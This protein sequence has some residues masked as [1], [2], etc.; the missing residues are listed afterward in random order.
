MSQNSHHPVSPTQVDAHA[1]GDVIDRHWHDDHQLIYVS[2]GVLA[3]RTEKGAWVAS[4][5]RAIWVPARIWHEHRVYGQTSLHVIGFRANAAP[6]PDTSPTVLTVTGLL[7]ELIIAC[8]EPNLTAP[9]ARRIRAVLNDRLR[10]AHVQPLTLPA[11]SDPRLAHACKVVVDDL[12][13]PRAVTWLAHHVG[14]GERTLARLFRAEFGM[15]YPQWRTGTRV[16]HAMIEL[17]EG[18]TVTQ[19][20]HRCGWA[21]TSAFI[22]TFARTMGQTPGAYRSATTSPSPARSST[23]DLADA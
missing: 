16:F 5:D 8:T 12:S 22:D 20:A 9:E 7:R 21:T 13:Q 19:T 15:T 18:A 23:S 3:I 2:T 17:A 6:L 11:A 1:A 10:H 14:T 4:R